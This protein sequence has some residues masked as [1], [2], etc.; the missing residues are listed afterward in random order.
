VKDISSQD[1]EMVGFWSNVHCLKSV[2]DV[3]NL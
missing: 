2:V 3:S 1:E